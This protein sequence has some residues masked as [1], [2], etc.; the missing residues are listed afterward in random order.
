MK[1]KMSLMARI[2]PNLKSFLI[3]KLKII[4]RE[5]FLRN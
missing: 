3:K 2:K 1:I 5:N 4:F